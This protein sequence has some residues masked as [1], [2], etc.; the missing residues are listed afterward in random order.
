MKTEALRAR[1]IA[2]KL[3]QR[4]HLSIC[5]FCILKETHHMLGWLFLTR[6]VCRIF[7]EQASFSLGMFI[8][9]FHKPQ[10]LNW[11]KRIYFGCMK[12]RFFFSSETEGRKKGE[13]S[14]KKKNHLNIKAHQNELSLKIHSE[15]IPVFQIFFLLWKIFGKFNPNSVTKTQNWNIFQ[16]TTN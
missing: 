5:I 1:A 14:S 7:L 6:K 11:K 16:S 8:D 15:K 10:I 4:V 2:S 13:I 3:L 12:S 9:T